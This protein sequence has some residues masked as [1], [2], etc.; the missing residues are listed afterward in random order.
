MRLHVEHHTVYEYARP[1]T[2]HRHRLV[3]RPREGHDVRVE[4]LRLTISPAHHLHWVRDV[5]DNSIALVDFF[6][7]ADR[8]RIVSDVVL[9]RD[10]P[11][12]DHHVHDP[13]RVP[14]P[15]RYD[16]LEMA[17][18]AT[19]ITPTYVEDVT[20]V[21]SWLGKTLGADPG[22][23][24]GTMLALCRTIHR[25][26]SYQR[27][28]EKGVQSPAATLD[29]RSGSCRDVATLMMDAA[30]VC[31]VAARF[32]SG[33]LHGTA[34]LAGHASTHAWTEVYLPTLGWRGFDPVVGGVVSTNHIAAGVSS[35]PRGVMP[36]T[37]TFTGA[38]GDYRGLR[39]S[40]RTERLDGTDFDAPTPA[41]AGQLAP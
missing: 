17:I 35:H 2:L 14:F 15:P 40:V 8:L 6:E 28:P 36:V 33:Y 38:P 24:E 13:W 9:E 22:D 4:R 5:F 25:T 19:Y 11:F 20:A 31:G 21:Q 34:S 27:R 7:P 1:V 3:V 23:A 41:G 37:G 12:P 26:V 30:R 32:V 16:P 29:R 39:V 10:A 18:T